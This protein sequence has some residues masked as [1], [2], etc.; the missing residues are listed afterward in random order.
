VKTNGQA[1]TCVLPAHDG[2]ILPDNRHESKDH[3][4]PWGADP[5]NESHGGNGKDPLEEDKIRSL[6]EMVLD[7]DKALQTLIPHPGEEG[8]GSKV[9]LQRA[10][11]AAGET[12]SEVRDLLSR[13][14]WDSRLAVLGIP[15]L[16]ATTY[17]TVVEATRTGN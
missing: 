12:L 3:N 17:R 5:R 2:R 1:S 16:A 11:I 10:T 9:V 13:D 8:K 4:A 6:A 7:R 15:S 14:Q